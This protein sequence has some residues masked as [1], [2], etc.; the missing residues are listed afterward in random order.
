MFLLFN[1][2]LPWICNLFIFFVFLLSPPGNKKAVELNNLYSETSH[3][4][5]ASS[6]LKSVSGFKDFAGGRGIV[7]SFLISTLLPLP[8][9]QCCI[10]HVLLGEGCFERS[11]D[12]WGLP[13]APR[14]HGFLV[15]Y[16]SAS[17]H[18]LLSDLLG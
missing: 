17:Y 16:L 3:L 9:F 1:V 14:F 15:T 11:T 5:C 10:S 7:I 6:K 18:T 2:D 12:T 8:R 4:W 13:L